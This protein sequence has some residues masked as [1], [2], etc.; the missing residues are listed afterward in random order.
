M[1]KQIETRAANRLT[2]GGQIVNVSTVSKEGVADVMTAAWN[3]PYDSDQVLV[4]LAKEHT[5]TRN[6][7]ETGK[8]VVTIPHEGQIEAI[9]KVG[10]I[11][12][13]DS[14]DKFE[15][16]GITP[17]VSA[18]LG[19]KIMPDPLA[20]IE[21]ELL[22]RETLVKTGVCIGRAISISV[23]E[24]LWDAEKSSFAAGFSRTLHYITE[25]AYYTNGRII[26]VERNYTNM[27][28]GS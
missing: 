17:E 8:F 23:Q 27:G 3:T 13:R 21:C 4:V 5:T 10:S 6:I 11:H 12:G 14:G 26:A 7:I 18:K 1:L 19:F 15:W 24:G 16:A 28:S 25:S 20:C 22:D 9:N 2:S